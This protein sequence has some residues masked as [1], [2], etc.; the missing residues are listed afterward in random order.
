MNLDDT[1]L[2]HFLSGKVEQRLNEYIEINKNNSNI[3]IAKNYCWNILK[4]I[5]YENILLIILLISIFIF[6]MYRY[7]MK[8]QRDNKIR[9]KMSDFYNEDIED[10]YDILEF[11]NKPFV[12]P[13]F[14]P[15]Y[16]NNRQANYALY[17]PDKMPHKKDGRNVSFV[18]D[19]VPNGTENGTNAK[20][21]NGRNLQEVSGRDL[22]E[23]GVPSQKYKNIYPNY[24]ARQSVGDDQTPYKRIACG[25]LSTTPQF[26]GEL[27][28]RNSYQQKSKYNMSH[29]ETKDRLSVECYAGLVDPYQ[30]PETRPAIR[31]AL[32]YPTNFNTTTHSFLANSIKKNQ[33]VMDEFYDNLISKDERLR[34]NLNIY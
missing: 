26:L 18:R 32:G 13:T 22:R 17:P 25:E 7:Y 16:P 30:G 10:T 5:I 20:L 8:K 4:N 33:K 19:M 27:D 29:P 3:T 11:Q 9:E 14:N 6:L 2:P 23:V 31:S 1:D 28:P 15:L 12:R 24:G 34:N 21:V